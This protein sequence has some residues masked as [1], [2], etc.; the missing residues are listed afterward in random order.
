MLCLSQT[1]PDTPWNASVCYSLQPQ[2]AQQL[3]SSLLQMNH[4]LKNI[5]PAP[6]QSTVYEYAPGRL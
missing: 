2:Q 6:T 3:N 1:L 4:N 5:S